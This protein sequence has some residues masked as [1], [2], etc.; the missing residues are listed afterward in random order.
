[1]SVFFHVGTAARGVGEDGVYVRAFE[2]VDGFAGKYDG[3]GFFA[4]VNEQRATAGLILWRDNLA[5]L[6]CKHA[7]GCGVYLGEKFS[8]DAAEKQ[9]D[10]GALCALRRS[11][12]RDG[13][14]GA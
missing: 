5:A 8:L 7:N 2:S 3:G 6:R 9:A 13:F 4:G 1:M 11:N 14:V 12:G 10:A